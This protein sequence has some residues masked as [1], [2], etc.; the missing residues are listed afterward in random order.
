MRAAIDVLHQV[1]VHVYIMVF[2]QVPSIGSDT[3]MN[4]KNVCVC[5]CVCVYTHTHTH[6]HIYIYMYIYAYSLHGPNQNSKDIK[7]IQD[8]E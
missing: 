5:V 3:G 2:S 8:E 7:I 6:T 4:L 1:Q